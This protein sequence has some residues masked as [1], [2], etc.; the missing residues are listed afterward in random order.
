MYPWFPNN[1]ILKF[2]IFNH[3]FLYGS[4]YKMWPETP[5]DNSNLQKDGLKGEKSQMTLNHIS[6]CLR[7]GIRIK[8][9]AEITSWMKK[10]I[11][12]ILSFHLTNEK[13]RVLQDE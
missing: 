6:T 4:P 7:E 13:V 5:Q 11:S 8:P 12:E 9:L 2:T 10:F 3:I 1:Y